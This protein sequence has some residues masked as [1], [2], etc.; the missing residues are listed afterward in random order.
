MYDLQKSV[1][2]INIKYINYFII[3]FTQSNDDHGN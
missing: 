3:N 2:F 1:L